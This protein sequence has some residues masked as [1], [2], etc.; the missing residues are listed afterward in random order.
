MASLSAIRTVLAHRNTRIFYGGSLVSWTGLW[1]QKVAVDWLAWELTHSPLWVGILA[2]CNLAPSVI[3]SPFAGAWADRMDRVRLTVVTQLITAA[4]AA[5]LAGLT[6]SGHIRVE[7]IAVLEVLLGTAQA[8]AQPARQTLVPGMVP[9]SELPGAI[10][11]NSLC[12]NLARSI[13]PGIGGLIVAA[14]GVVPAML[15]NCAAYLFASVTLPLLRLHAGARRGHAPTGSVLRE[16]VDGIMY[17]ARHPGMGPL[18]LFAGLLG[19]LTRPV[20]EMLPPYID[21]LFSQG[22]QGLATVSSAIGMAAMVGGLI[23]AM[24]GRLDGLARLAVAAGAVMVLATAG[25]VATHHFGFAVVCAATLGGAT[26]MHGISVQ[27]LLQS[28]TSGHMLGRVLSLWG[29]IG[30]AAPALGAVI[31]GGLAEFAGLQ[32]PVLAGAAVASVACVLVV[33]R[34]PRIARALE[35]GDAA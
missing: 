24:R 18:F 7:Y 14:A 19:V 13:G 30:R 32:L 15:V 31:Y 20:Q 27:T 8:F 26:T 11:L 22:A 6:L 21:R 17:V 28:S 2:F 16:V 4:H 25:F 34:L 3:V 5:T 12:Y 33:R 10:A 29:M 1:V 9:R 23:V 35:R